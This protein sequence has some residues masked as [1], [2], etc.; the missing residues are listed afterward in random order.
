MWNP[1]TRELL[2]LQKPGIDDNKEVATGCGFGFDAI[3]NEYKVIQLYERLDDSTLGYEVLTLGT[4]MSWRRP[5][6]Q[7]DVLLLPK[8]KEFESGEGAIFVEG[9]LYWHATDQILCFDVSRQRFKLIQIPDMTHLKLGSGQEHLV[10]IDSSLYYMKHDITYKRLHMWKI[11]SNCADKKNIWDN[12]YSINVSRISVP[13]T[14]IAPICIRNKKIY[15][16]YRKGL[17]CYD[18][19]SREFLKP[20]FRK[21]D[22][23]FEFIAYRKSILCLK[24]IVGSSF[25]M[26]LEPS[27]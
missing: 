21:G 26:S 9:S 17:A 22:D 19:E 14:H 15:L 20:V 8:F 16:R 27:C 5:I 3:H 11:Q 12:V 23:Y 7:K 13:D 2:T 4:D 25:V 10:G 24:D 6:H 18:T 1:I